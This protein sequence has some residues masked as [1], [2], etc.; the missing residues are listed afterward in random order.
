MNKCVSLS[1][2]FWNKAINPKDKENGREEN[3]RKWTANE[4]E[5][6]WK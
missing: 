2:V 1:A 5:I 4:F 6:E 3:F